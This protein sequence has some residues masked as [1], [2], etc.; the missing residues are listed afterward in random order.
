[1]ARARTRGASRA[2]RSMTRS[3][4]RDARAV[5]RAV[6]A[7]AS[8]ALAALACVG[9]VHSAEK[10]AAPPITVAPA[11]ARDALVAPPRRDWPSNGG[12]WLNQR[13]SPLTAIDRGNVGSLKGVWRARLGGSGVGTKYSGE[14]QPLVYDG[15]I[16]NGTGADDVF[17]LGVD[18]G[19]ILWSYKANLDE[20]N[21]VVCCGWTSR[22]VALGPGQVYAGHLAGHLCASGGVALG[23]G[24]VCVAQ[25]DGRLVA[26]DQKTG[27]VEWSVQ[28]ER[29]Q[30]GLVITA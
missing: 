9:V 30:D 28:A 2:D 20:S 13:F 18:S 7:A 16:Y 25:L 8:G 10:A 24:K 27:K 11:F 6:C 21:D 1:M 29:W 12:S 23:A 3:A 26:L 5:G 22:G 14:A 4:A 19:E 15:T 17:A